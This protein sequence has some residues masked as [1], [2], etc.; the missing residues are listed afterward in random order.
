MLVSEV[1]GNLAVSCGLGLLGVS[2]LS[3]GSKNTKLGADA[4]AV[5]YNK[6][7]VLKGGNQSG[8]GGTYD[9]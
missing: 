6:N 5:Q 9:M 4:A 8:E 1:K 7:K 2:E 3:F